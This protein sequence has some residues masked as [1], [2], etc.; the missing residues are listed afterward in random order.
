MKRLEAKYESYLVGDDFDG[1][2]GNDDNDFDA[3]DVALL[4]GNFGEDLGVDFLGF[5]ELGLGPLKV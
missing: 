1:E 5:K 4:S 2:G 3:G